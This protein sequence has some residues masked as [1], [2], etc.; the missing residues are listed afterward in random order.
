M[1]KIHLWEIA[2]ARSGDKGD[3]SNVGIVAYNETGY[4]WLREVLTPERVKAHFHEICF[5]PVERFE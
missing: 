2:Y 1:K 4:G 3:A 5:G